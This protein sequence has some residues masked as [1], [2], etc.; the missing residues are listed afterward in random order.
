VHRNLGVHITFV[1]CVCAARLPLARCI[2]TDAHTHSSTNLDSWTWTQLRLMKV[3]GNGAATDFFARH[4][5]GASLLAP[6]TEGATKYNSS[7]AR[8]YREELARRAAADANGAPT[9]SRVL[10]PGMQGLES[11]PK[12]AEK[13]ADEED[14]FDDWDTPAK[15]AATPKAAAAAKPALPGIGM[16]P[17]PAAAAPKP[18]AAAPAPAP[19]PAAPAAPVTSSSLRPAAARGASGSSAGSALGAVRAKPKAA[20]GATKLGASKLGGVRR[21]AAAPVLDY[22]AAERAAAEKEAEAAR[23]E[24]AARAGAE[25]DLAEKMARAAIAAAGAAEEKAKANVAAGAANKQASAEGGKVE[26]QPKEVR[27]GGENERLGMGFGRIG[28]SAERVRE[29]AE[30][31][32]K[33]KYAAGE[34]SCGRGPECSV[35]R[36]AAR[37]R[38]GCAVSASRS[39]MCIAAKLRSIEGRPAHVLTRRVGACAA[40]HRLASTCLRTATVSDFCRRSSSKRLAPSMLACS[41][42]AM[43]VPHELCLLRL[44]VP[45]RLCRPRR[46]L[47]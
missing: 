10:F 26:L 12:A 33:A 30:A 29:R 39:S 2:R 1:R 32:R 5:G 18:A 24:A 15:P 31:E 17:A 36:H 6:G 42:R 47:L 38:K 43:P 35:R 4:S 7:A 13:K 9:S 3:G 21:G 45:L 41:V 25:K 11:A 37:G 8:A 46:R 44:V 28:V 14:F 34:S 20:L 22:E 16:R 40:R 27:L 19:A 23:L